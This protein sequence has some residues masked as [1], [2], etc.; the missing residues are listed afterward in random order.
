[1]KDI[2]VTRQRGHIE[3][4][5]DELKNAKIV[6]QNKKLRTKFYEKLDDYMKDCDA[7]NHRKYKSEMPSRNAS[8]V[9]KSIRVSKVK[10]RKSEATSPN[11]GI[12]TRKISSPNYFTFTANL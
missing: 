2:L 5:K 4:L 7:V 10:S 12:F 1:V 8:I 3:G 11:T 6:L 9:G